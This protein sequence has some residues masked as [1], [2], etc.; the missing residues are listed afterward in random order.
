MALEMLDLLL[1]EHGASKK[2]CRLVAGERPL[3]KAD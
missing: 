1:K 2:G 3:D